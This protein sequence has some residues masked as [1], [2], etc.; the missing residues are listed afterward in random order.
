MCFSVFLKKKRVARSEESEE[1]KPSSPE[2]KRHEALNMG[3]KGTLYALYV[4]IYVC[5]YVCMYVPK[6]GLCLKY[7]T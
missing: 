7:K 1:H 5:M 2:S 6:L 4:S 3:S